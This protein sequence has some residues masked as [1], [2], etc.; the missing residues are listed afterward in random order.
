[1]ETPIVAKVAAKNYDHY[2]ALEADYSLQYMYDLMGNPAVVRNV[3]FAGHLHHGKS[4]LMDMLIQESQIRK[5]GW[6]LEKNYKW[7]DTRVDEQ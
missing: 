2:E 5:H 1:M 6:N 3:M 7:L 4:L